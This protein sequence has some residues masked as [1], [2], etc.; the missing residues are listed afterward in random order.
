MVSFP[1]NFP[2]AIPVRPASPIAPAWARTPDGKSSGGG[3][4]AEDA[5]AKNN[6]PQYGTN[7]GEPP[8]RGQILD[9]TV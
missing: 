6:A 3:A 9:I 5:S 7:P 8:R 1:G 2:Y 4:A